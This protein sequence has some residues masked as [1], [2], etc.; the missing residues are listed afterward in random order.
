M[1]KK[2]ESKK[3]WGLYNT[4]EDPDFI[5]KLDEIDIWKKIDNL[6]AAIFWAIHDSGKPWAAKVASKELLDAQYN[7]E[8][9][10][11]STRK[12]GVEFSREPSETEH[13]ERSKSYLAW[14]TFWYNHFNSM[15]KEKYDQFVD[16]KFSGKDISKYMPKGS[17]KDTYTEDVKKH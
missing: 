2:K 6:S 7:L 15:S 1:A 10:V 4:L 9:L 14:Y 13:V 17:W 16:D 5:D 8:Y 3:I 11:Y 12:Y